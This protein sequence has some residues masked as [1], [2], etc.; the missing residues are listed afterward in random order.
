MNEIPYRNTSPDGWWIAGIMVRAQWDHEPNPR[1]RQRCLAWETLVLVQAP[2][3]EAAYEKALAEGRMHEAAG[4]FWNGD[5]ETQT[6]RWIFEGLTLLL[7]LH[8]G[9]EDGSEI[10]WTEHENRTVG[11][12]RSRVCAK[13]QLSVFDDTPMPN[14]QGV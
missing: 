13:E 4:T 7:P 9:L 1:D 12:V 5:D 14:P 11:F 3:R 10:L 8:Y 2:D 6:G